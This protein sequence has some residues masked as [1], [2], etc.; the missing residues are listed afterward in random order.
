MATCASDRRKKR[1]QRKMISGNLITFGMCQHSEGKEEP[2]GKLRKNNL[3]FKPVSVL[4]VG[5]CSLWKLDLIA[6]RPPNEN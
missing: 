1:K 3:Q 2:K 5:K 6:V 4:Y